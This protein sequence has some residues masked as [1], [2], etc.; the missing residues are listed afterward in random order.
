ML[1]TDSLPRV[2]S[3]AGATSAGGAPTPEPKIQLVGCWQD[4]P[5]FYRENND[6][7]LA[8]FH[9]LVRDDYDN[10]GAVR[11]REAFAAAF[12]QHV[13]VEALP[14]YSAS[15]GGGSGQ[16]GDIKPEPGDPGE[17]GGQAPAESTEQ[18]APEYDDDDP[19]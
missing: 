6:E 3:V 17:K 4:G 10:A 2:A 7:L 9:H 11:A 19:E 14:G 15:G 18:P 12:P 8:S 13:R 5:D 1:I 16:G